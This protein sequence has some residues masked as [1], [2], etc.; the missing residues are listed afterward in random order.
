MIQIVKQQIR[1][2]VVAAQKVSGISQAKFAVKLGI[3]GAT[4]SQIVNNNLELISDQ[5]WA[6]ISKAVGFTF[7]DWRPANTRNMQLIHNTLKVC[8][9][10]G[11]VFGLS[12][13]AG[14]GKSYACEQY[15]SAHENVIYVRC[16]E[17]WNR[18]Q[19]HTAMVQALGVDPS[20]YTTMELVGVMTDALMKRPGALVIWDE[21]DKLGNK[22]TLFIE[23]YNELRYTVGF[24]ICGTPSLRKFIERGARIDKRGFKEVYSRLGSMFLKLSE[25]NPNDIRMICESNGLTDED[26][27]QAVWFEFLRVK[28][29]RR[30]E[31][32]INKYKKQL[33]A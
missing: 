4:L 28:D 31:L 11:A 27:I 26:A 14:Q 8:Q 29:L 21:A 32:L 7:T 5:M 9:E 15:A 16:R 20:G 23:L 24:F 2:A 13:D 10:E 19:F 6:K 3:S 1:E 17:S 18:K 33:A 25:P 12:A 30:V 22:L